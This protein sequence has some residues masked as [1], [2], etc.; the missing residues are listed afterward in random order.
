[1]HNVLVSI[2]EENDPREVDDIEEEEDEAVREHQGY[3]ITTQ[4]SQRA[5]AKRDEIAK[6]M[7]NDYQT[8]KG[9]SKAS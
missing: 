6:A 1:M 3:A 5:A 4:E 9:I 8:R 7:W 2:Q